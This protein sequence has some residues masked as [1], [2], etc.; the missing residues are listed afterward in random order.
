MCKKT[1]F[2]LGHADT[3]SDV[4][5]SLL[6]AI[7]QH[8]TEYGVTEFF[9]GHHGFFDSLA[10]RALREAKVHHPDIRIIHVQPYH[11]GINPS[12]PEGFDESFYPFD[13][14]VHPRFVISK[15]NRKMID[16][17]DFIIA[18]VWHCGNSGAFFEYAKKR[19]AS[20]QLH[21]ENLKASI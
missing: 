21:M 12:I 1:C 4:Y 15:A 19:A 10:L 3:P 2:F 9:V 11:P 5:P 20:S 14:P 17:C 18:Y 8:I 6:A 16:T 13:T 7:E